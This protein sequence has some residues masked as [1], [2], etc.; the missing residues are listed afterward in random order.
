MAFLVVAGA[1]LFKGIDTIFETLNP[2]VAAKKEQESTP[3]PPKP[4]LQ[5]WNIPAIYEDEVMYKQI[6]A[7]DLQI[8]TGTVTRRGRTLS[9]PVT[10]A[11]NTAEPFSLTVWTSS[12]VDDSGIDFERRMVNDRLIFPK[13][14][15]KYTLQAA[16]GSGEAEKAALVEVILTREGGQTLKATRMVRAE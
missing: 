4:D 15:F 5:G 6:V 2:E 8:A 12:P 9:I 13:G 14:S 3:K 11:N 16:V 7:K 1:L 10:V